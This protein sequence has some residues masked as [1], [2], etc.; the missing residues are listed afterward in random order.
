LGLAADHRRVRPAEHGISEMMVDL[1]R[2][3]AK[4]LDE[5]TLFA[6]HRMVTKGRSELTDIGRYRS[7]AEPMQ[8]VAGAIYDPQVQ[9][10]CRARSMTRMSISR[11]RRP[12]RCRRR[13]GAI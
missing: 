9:F 3:Y 8:V 5:R 11:R 12:P 13:C 2:H 10:E 4:P 1:F 6:W 7:H